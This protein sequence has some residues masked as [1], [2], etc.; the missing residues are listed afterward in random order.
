M[1]MIG[2]MRSHKGLTKSLW[3]KFI[4]SLRLQFLH[5]I[6]WVDRHRTEINKTAFNLAFVIKTLLMQATPNNNRLLVISV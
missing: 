2:K 5:N 6:T 4:S 3:N 1:R